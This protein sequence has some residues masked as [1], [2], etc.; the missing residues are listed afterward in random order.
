MKR[1]FLSALILPVAATIYSWT[2]THPPDVAEIRAGVWPIS[3]QRVD[4]R[5]GVSFSLIF[6]DQ[7]E[8]FENVM[9]T[10]DFANMKQLKYLDDGLAALKHNG[11]RAVYKDFSIA[12]ADK[13]YE[14]TFY[15]LRA[16]YGQTVFRQRH[17]DLL[18]IAIKEW[19][20]F[21]SDSN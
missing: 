3:L 7:T 13:K 17:K 18:R 6:R 19:V 20:D 15:I 5:P 14:D 1:L 21:F 11:D 2:L 10:L 16:N 12:R 8:Q 9:D 4:D